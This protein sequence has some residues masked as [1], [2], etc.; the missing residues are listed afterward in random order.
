[1]IGLCA[2][3]EL[4]V[5]TIFG[6]VWRPSVPLLQILCI[7]GLFWP[8]HVLN[9][10]ALLAQGRSGIYLQ[11][12][13]VKKVI[14]ISAVIAAAPFGLV[15]LAWS[16]VCVSLVCFVVNAWFSG[17]LLQ[18]GPIAQ[19][20]D[21]G[22]CLLPAVLMGGLVVIADQQ[23]AAPAMIKLPSLIAGGIAAYTI[24]TFFLHR[25]LAVELLSIWRS[26]LRVQVPEP[27][28]NT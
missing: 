4:V 6:E 8:L 14:S 2:T 27:A 24:L 13:I 25:K 10:T 20:R 9:L 18:Y 22:K 23:I 26:R 28:Q 3:S 19:G 1:M 12:E 15:A 21:L 11:I 7:A 16:Q 17:K 5:V